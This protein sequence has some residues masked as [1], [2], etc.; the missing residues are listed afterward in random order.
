MRSRIRYI[1]FSTVSENLIQ[2]PA[3]TDVGRFLIWCNSSKLHFL[4][5]Q[6][7]GKKFSS[8]TEQLHFVLFYFYNILNH[9]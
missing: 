9:I 7:T 5:T 1:H 2:L 3:R 4:P 6:I 8:P